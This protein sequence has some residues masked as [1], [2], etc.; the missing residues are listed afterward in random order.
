MLFFHSN[1]AGNIS[2]AAANASNTVAQEVSIPFIQACVVEPPRTPWRGMVRKHL[3]HDYSHWLKREN[4]SELLSGVLWPR[5]ASYICRQTDLGEKMKR[6]ILFPA[7]LQNIAFQELDKDC[8]DTLAWIKRNCD[9]D[10]ANGNLV[11]Y[12]APARAPL[13]P[14]RCVNTSRRC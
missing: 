12:I 2:S 1:V 14:R 10:M 13:L 9:E 5:M 11:V 4:Q 7:E 3:E 8:E 6:K